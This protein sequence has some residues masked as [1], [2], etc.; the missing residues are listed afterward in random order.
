MMIICR[1]SAQSATKLV[2]SEGSWLSKQAAGGWEHGETNDCLQ[3]V[4]N[5][6][7]LSWTSTK[8]RLQTD[9]ASLMNNTAPHRRG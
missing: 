7:W 8:R 3:D 6:V 4:N 2:A 1:M 5:T 9:E